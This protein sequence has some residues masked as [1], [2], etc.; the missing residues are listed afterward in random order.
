MDNTVPEVERSAV[1]TAL[2]ATP[3]PSHFPPVPIVRLL[4]KQKVHQET[5]WPE[6]S[7]LP[8]LASLVGSR[9][10]LLF[11]ILEL[12]GED[13]EWLNQAPSYWDIN[14]GY[15]RLEKFLGNLSVVNDT[16]ERGVKLIQV[17]LKKN[18]LIKQ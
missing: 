10:W 7:S 14:P 5:F 12:E 2:S 11:N 8:S 13:V 18:N 17:I 15:C 9:T 6:D 16:A 3:R 1:A 4:P